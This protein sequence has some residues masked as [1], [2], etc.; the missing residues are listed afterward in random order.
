MKS[1]S[2]L[3]VPSWLIFKR[4]LNKGVFPTCSSTTPIF[5]LSAKSHVKNCRSIS[6]LSHIAKLFEKLILKNILPS[7]NPTLIDKL[8]NFRLGCLTVMNLF[9]LNDFILEAFES[10]CQVDVIF[11]DFEKAFNRVNYNLQL[12]SLKKSGFLW[13]V[14]EMVWIILVWKVSMDEN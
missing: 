14:I 2:F 4:S 10:N 5:K 12:L 8:Y 6:I 1:L 11:T 3:F 13:S 9:V 7:I